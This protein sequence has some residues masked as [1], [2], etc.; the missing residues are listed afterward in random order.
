VKFRDYYEVLGVDRK[1]SPEE[2]QK[3]YRKLARKYHPDINKTKEAEDRFKEINEA[4]EVLSDADN[5]KRYDALGANWKEGQ[6]FQPPPEWGQQFNNVRSNF[7]QGGGEDLNGFSDFFSALFGNAAFGGQGGFRGAGFGGGS[8]FGAGRFGAGMGEE[9]M[10]TPQA[11]EAEFGISVEDAFAGGPKMIQLRDASGKTRTLN[12]KIPAGSLEGTAIRIR[13]SSGEPDLLLRVKLLPHS[14]YS[15]SGSD[16]IVKLPVAPW[17]AALGSKVDV[18]LPDGTIKIS[19]PAGSQSGSRL[20]L[21]GRGFPLKKDQGRGDV[22]VEIKIVIPSKLSDAEREIY[23]RLAS[24]SN[25]NP[26][27]AA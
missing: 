3:A 20:R 6:D 17:E 1:A 11:Q 16:L 23:E 18:A 24:V 7:G 26:R 5:R 8:P 22:L 19:V 14:R 4:N 21:R 27:A 9:G 15:V 10:R 13:G 2:I 25:F 12:V